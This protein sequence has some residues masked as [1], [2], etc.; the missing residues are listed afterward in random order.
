MLPFLIK[1]LIKLRRAGWVFWVLSIVLAL[2][3]VIFLGP[4]I[5]G[6]GS[7][8]ITGRTM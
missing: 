6:V 3:F 8:F 5:I 1:R 7:I 4:I 2:L